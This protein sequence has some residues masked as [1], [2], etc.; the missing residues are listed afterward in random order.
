[1]N[2]LCIAG[3]R[4]IE[5]LATRKQ[6][7]GLI[8][9]AVSEGLKLLPRDIEEVISGGAAGVDNI[10]EWWAR[11]HDIKV[12]QVK[13]DWDKHGKS[14]GPIRN[15]KMATMATHL[16]VIWDG[17]SRG[18]RSMIEAWERHHGHLNNAVLIAVGGE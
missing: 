11:D 6:V 3:S 15:V 4:H 9:H 17:S 2:K 16:I 1:M 14:A 7:K 8:G 18:A 10:G 12:V 5:L 13:P